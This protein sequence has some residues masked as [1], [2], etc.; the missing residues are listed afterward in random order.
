M[1]AYSTIVQ[2]PQIRALV[3][4]NHLERA[5][6]DSLYPRLLFRGEATPV[7]VA[8]HVGDTFLATG[9][10]LIRKRMKPI[11]PGQD[12]AADDYQKE[13]WSVQLQQYAGSIPTNMPTDI[14]AIA[15]LF[16]RNSQQSGL[17]AARTLN[18]IVRNKMFNA[19]LS[20]WTVADGAQGPSTTLRV[21]RL[22]GFTR[23]R[24]SGATPTVRFDFVSVSNPLEIHVNTGTFAVPIDTIVHVT[25]YTP[26][27][28]GDET[29]PG[30][31]TL[32]AAVTVI[33]RAYVV[34]TNRTFL[35]R[36]SG[37]FQVD[38]I[39]ASSIIRF[40]DVRA[41]LANFQTNNVPE[42][43]EGAYHAHIDPTAHAELYQDPE[44]QRVHTSMPDGFAYKNYAVGFFLGTIFIR[45]T[46]NPLISTVDAD[47]GVAQDGTKFSL[48][49][50]F[51]GELTHNGATVAAGAIPVHRTLFTAAGGIMEYYQDMGLLLTEAGINGKVGQWQI[52][53]DGIEIMS[54][55]IRMLLRA[56]ID[57]LLQ[58]VD[59]TWTFIGDWP[60]RTDSTTGDVSY[61]KRFA[62][63][64]SA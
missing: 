4:E 12:P 11:V 10:G 55:R 58:V 49:D 8:A 36:P 5:F 31:V 9:V 42:H 37:G 59:T 39:N 2:D 47:D 33:N 27:N 35:Q 45:N 18:A 41:V 48:N 51:A 64:E 34:S 30:T 21:K 26:D 29:G 38:T 50:P 23:A 25:A 62:V 40:S 24:Q 19:A 53:N 22:N 20:G 16:Y 28:V 46:E 43:P 14:V 54:D 61:Y 44:W 60:V 57:K 3:Q 56:P 15:S 13:Q 6:H 63:V 1:P 7:E 17:S 32:D 52:S